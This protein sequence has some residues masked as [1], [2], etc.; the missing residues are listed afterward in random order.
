MNCLNCNGENGKNIEKKRYQ[1]M[2][3]FNL[4][5]QIPSKYCPTCFFWNVEQF[6]YLT[7]VIS[8]LNGEK[9]K[10]IKEMLNNLDI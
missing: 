3:I 4:K 8:I 6:L 7:W 1:K 10:K 9:G 2:K 5:T